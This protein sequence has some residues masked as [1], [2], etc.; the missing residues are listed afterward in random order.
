MPATVGSDAVPKG[1]GYLHVPAKNTKGFLSVQTF[2]TPYLQTTVIHK[3]DLVKA[4]NVRVKD[5][6]SDSI[7]KYKD[8]GA[9]TY[10]AK[11]RM[12][13]SKDVIIHG[14]LIDDKCYTG[15]LIPPDLD[16]SDPKASPATSSILAIESDPEF[17]EQCQKAT[18]LAIHGYHE[19]VETQL[20]EE[21]TKLPTQFHLLPFHEYIQSNNPAS[22]IKAATE[23]L[24][25]HQRLGHPSDYY[26]FNAHGHADGVPQFPHMTCRLP[27][28]LP[29]A[30][31]SWSSSMS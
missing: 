29:S 3:R 2:Y 21:M 23:R 15:A 9:F 17:A 8:A 7:A 22:T 26:L 27:C 24:L 13:S 6:E 19:A 1:F 12:N 18:I 10:H 11:H 25:W 5:I 4:S 16:P 20:R 30:V 14:I 28:D 31:L